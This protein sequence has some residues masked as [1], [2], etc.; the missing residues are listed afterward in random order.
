MSKHSPWFQHCPP[1]YSSCESLLFCCSH[2]SVKVIIDRREGK[3]FFYSKSSLGPNYLPKTKASPTVADS[4]AIIVH[5]SLTH[6]C[7]FIMAGSIMWANVM[8]IYLS[9]S[10]TYEYSLA[11]IL[12]GN[13][14][15][16]MRG[17][18]QQRCEPGTNMICYVQNSLPQHIHADTKVH[19]LQSLEHLNSIMVALSQIIW[20]SL[21]G[22]IIVT[23]VTKHTRGLWKWGSHQLWC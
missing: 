22:D 3:S 13:V 7:S 16:V 20:K 12:L 17:D 8:Y 18:L 9:A 21:L 5:L 4:L 15:K 10:C 23:L 2:P 1:L 19:V 11:F 14:T 6:K